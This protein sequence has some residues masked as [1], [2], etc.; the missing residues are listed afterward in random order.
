MKL[1]TSLIQIPMDE[2][3]KLN[4]CFHYL[5]P[6]M[7]LAAY[8]VWQES[9]EHDFYGDNK[10]GERVLEGT[11]DFYTLEEN[12]SKLDELEAAMNAMGASWALTSVMFENETNLI[13][14]T[15]DWEI[16]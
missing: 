14:F 7:T 11:L 16:S 12:D 6:E 1:L 9:G 2:F 15:W 3:G 8:A 13:H 10:K 4:Y 5:K